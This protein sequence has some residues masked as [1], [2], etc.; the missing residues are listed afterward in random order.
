MPHRGSK[1][2]SSILVPH[3]SLISRGSGPVH[4]HAQVGRDNAS[5]STP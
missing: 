1:P 5:D 4:S 3:D 2:F